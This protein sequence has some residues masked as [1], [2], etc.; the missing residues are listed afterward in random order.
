[1][2]SVC[3]ILK[4]FL[5]YLHQTGILT[6]D[7]SQEIESPRR[8]RLAGLPGS[9]SREEAQRMIEMV[10]L[11]HSRFIALREDKDAREV[12]REN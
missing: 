12:W 6:R 10:D 8:Y 1:M 3:S 2:Q 7:L 9:I 4:T 11:R 5:R